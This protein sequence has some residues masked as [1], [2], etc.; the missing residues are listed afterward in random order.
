MN[1]LSTIIG[2]KRDSFD[3]FKNNICHLV[4]NTGELNFIKE[5]LYSNEPQILYEKEWFAECLY[6]VAMTDYLS[7]KNNIPIYN[8]YDSLRAHKLNE[9]LYPSSIYMLYLLT[10]DKTVLDDSFNSSI[11]EF[12]R[13]NIVENNIE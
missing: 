7:R 4:K 9:P 6:L 3:N 2:K 12:K 10:N 11:P 13:F 1:I 8:G 5:V